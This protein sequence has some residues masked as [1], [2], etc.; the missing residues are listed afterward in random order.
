VPCFS[1][2]VRELR[3]GEQTIVLTTDGLLEFGDRPFERPAAFAA[4]IGTSAV[5]GDNLQAMLD[6][7][8]AS[9]ARDSATVIAWRATCNEQ[10]LMP[11][12]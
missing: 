12:D 7:A 8:H 11:T 3:Q 1:S 4:A 9:G 10:G 5:L 2:G 6:H